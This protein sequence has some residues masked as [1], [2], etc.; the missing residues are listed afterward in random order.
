MQGACRSAWYARR[1]DA[2]KSATLKPLTNGYRH[3]LPIHVCMHGY[4]R[5]CVFQCLETLTCTRRCFDSA[6]S[7]QARP[8][9]SFDEAQHL[10]FFQK[11]R[12]QTYEG[13]EPYNYK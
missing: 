10:C 1:H 9:D 3:L 6:L 11:G 2:R 4:I 8:A 7:S 13:L 5:V 12:L